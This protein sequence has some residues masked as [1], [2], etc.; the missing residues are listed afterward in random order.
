MMLFYVQTNEDGGVYIN[1]L[2]SDFNMQ[3]SENPI[4]KDVYTA[5]RK[6]TTQEDYLE[7]YN[8]VE[9][10]FSKLI[11]ENTDI[12]QLTKR[13]IPATRQTWEDTVYYV[14]STEG[15]ESTESTEVTETTETTE[16]EETETSENTEN[17]QDDPEPVIQKVRI[18]ADSSVRI[19]K[20]PGTSHD[21]VGDAYN[22]DE[23]V[24]LGV[25]NDENGEEWTKIQFT[26][27]T[28]AY[29]KSSFVEIV[30]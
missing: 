17:T 29:V 3:Y 14:T 13:T 10:A 7:L 23:F 24:K 22:G 18:K 2:Y 9:V 8:E 16:S 19:R 4:S 28:V 25:E 27:S 5:L 20:G 26:D 1:N 11:K 21:K 12:Y 30:E 6:V 15:M